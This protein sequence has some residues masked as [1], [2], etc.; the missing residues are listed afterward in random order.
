MNMHRLDELNG[1]EIKELID[2]GQL[3]IEELDYSSLMKVFDHETEMLVFGVGDM[4]FINK[5][6]ALLE[7]NQN[8]PTISS[9]RL[10]GILGKTFDEH[11]T[12]TDSDGDVRKS[13]RTPPCKRRVLRK[14]AVVAAIVALLVAGT[15]LIAAAFDVN[16]VEYIKKAVRDPGGY[17][18]ECDGYTV[19][20]SDKEIRYPSIEQLAEE[21]DLD[22][23]YPSVF[24]EDISVR[25]VALCTDH[26]GSTT[27]RL[28]TYDVYV[29]FEIQ[30]SR[31][32]FDMTLCEKM[33]INGDTYVIQR[34]EKMIGACRYLDG[35][36]YYISARNED[37]LVLIIEGLRRS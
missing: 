1:Q 18:F 31:P 22:I 2:N 10:D 20:C 24:P 29:G 30:L 27:V 17:V 5:C 13:R 16:I 37:E 21:N 28:Y 7:K 15:T 11:V 32:E 3:N 26:N 9:E 34:G 4:D 19:Y 35:N 36:V 6:S 25:R 14:I 33:E 23:L 8:E 12:V